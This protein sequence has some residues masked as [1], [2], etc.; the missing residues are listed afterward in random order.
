MCQGSTS[1]SDKRDARYQAAA[2]TFTEDGSAPFILALSLLLRLNMIKMCFACCAQKMRFAVFI[3]LLFPRLEHLLKFL[4]R[5]VEIRETHRARAPA[6]L[7]SFHF[8]FVSGIVLRTGSELGFFPLEEHFTCTLSVWETDTE[9][10]PQWPSLVRLKASA[11]IT[12][13]IG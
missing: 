11:H 8:P 12:S 7:V 1:V 2:V 5:E 9:Q 6:P 4:F 10:Q 3:Y 13:S